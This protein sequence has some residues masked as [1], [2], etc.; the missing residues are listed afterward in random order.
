MG[1]SWDTRDHHPSATK[2]QNNTAPSSANKRQKTDTTPIKQENVVYTI[3]DL[4]ESDNESELKTLRAEN[5]V[6]KA[7]A[8]ADGVI[9]EKLKASDTKD[10]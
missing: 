2:R 1:L 3:L 10:P 5:K 4:S 6:L 9:E 7:K 8:K